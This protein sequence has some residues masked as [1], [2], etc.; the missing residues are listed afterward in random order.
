MQTQEPQGSG[1]PG[2]H[3]TEDTDAAGTSTLGLGPADWAAAWAS[4]MGA[5]GVRPSQSDPTR[6]MPRQV[7]RSLEALG[8]V[9]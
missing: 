5:L 4:P 8:H 6:R 3:L 2:T 7:A 9:K 1:M